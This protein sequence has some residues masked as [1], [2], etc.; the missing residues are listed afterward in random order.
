MSGEPENLMLVYL[1]RLDGKMDR[2]IEDM[3]DLK[4]R[5]TTLE[6]QIGQQAATEGSHYAGL[7]IRMDRMSND[8]DRIK[9]RLDLHE[10]AAA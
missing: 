9:S 3:R 2:L 8:I 1:R 4:H 6:I 7:A 10:L 5:V